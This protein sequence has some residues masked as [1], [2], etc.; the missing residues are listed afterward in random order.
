MVLIIA[1]KPSLAR[2]IVAGIGK[3]DRKDGYFIGEGYLVSWAFGHLFSLADVE[4]YN[5]AP[6]GETGWTLQNLP[7][8]PE[9]FHFEL[10]KGDDKKP[11]S[12][13]IRQFKLLEQLCNRED[14]DTIV[15]AGDADREGEIIVRLCVSH[16]LRAPK[17]QLRLWLP[18][19]TPETVRAALADMKDEDAY[20]HLANEG[21]ARTY[22]DWLYGV[23]LTRFATIR[24]GTLLRVGRVI[25][26]IVRAIYDRD[27]EIRNFS[28]ETYYMLRSREENAG[29]VLELWGKEKFSLKEIEK[30]KALAEQYNATG[31][32]VISVKN[33]QDRI[34]PGKL[35]SLSALQNVLGKKY[36][37]SMAESL[38]IVQKLYEEGY[39][40]YPRTNSE[41]LATAEKDKIRAI[42]SGVAKLGYP[43]RFKDSKYIFDDSK[44]ESHSALTPTYKIPDSTKL[45]EKQKQVY[46]TVMRRFVAVFC[47]EDCLA[48]KSEIRIAVGDLEEFVLKGTVIR[49]AGWTKYDD[50]NQKD[51]LL[52]ALSEGEEVKIRFEPAER[53][54]TP[55]KHYTIETLNNYLK[56]PFK[57]DKA[58]AKELEQNGEVDDAED[59]KA[60]FEGLELGTEATR[61][62]IIDNARKSGYIELKKDVYSILPGGERLIHSLERLGIQMD[63]Y[64]TSEMGKALKSVYHG[65]MTVEESVALAKGEIRRIF[66]EGAKNA[67]PPEDTGSLG[68]I[69]GPC[70]KCG[71]NVIRG[72]RAYGCMGYKDGCDFK[73]GLTI[74]S[75]TIPKTAMQ[76]LLATGKTPK[77]RGFISK[78]GRPFDGALVIRDGEAVFDF[79]KPKEAPKEKKEANTEKPKR[80]RKTTKKKEETEK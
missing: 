46:G 36:K 33:K 64:K 61:T 54:T 10:R 74:C 57:D 38:E 34:P 80:Q 31:A 20:A 17:R 43:V 62:G 45:S 76:A 67:L 2:N 55:P 63:K 71:A 14:V 26:P 53:Q 18:D 16:A 27:M 79:A 60:I 40:T 70:P 59:Y 8:F 49:Q 21:F 23:N 29:E 3:M 13:V 50:Y 41:Y 24:A 11:D 35:Y 65:Q 51:K 48:D 1:E 52:P 7:C 66:D 47:A 58:K 78:T 56:N 12:G 32:K 19:Q 28:P 68:E 9:K 77:L 30:C 73:V 39:L 42:L 22:I 72:N 4:H 37:M 5:P 44:I 69:M 6:E 75:R 15:N 25:V